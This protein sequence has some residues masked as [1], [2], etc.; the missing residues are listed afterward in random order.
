MLGRALTRGQGAGAG[1]GPPPPWR[2]RS[3]GAASS[4]VLANPSF[5]SMALEGLDALKEGSWLKD[6]QYEEQKQALAKMFG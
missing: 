1:D 3:T 2:F 4:N 6:K 5:L